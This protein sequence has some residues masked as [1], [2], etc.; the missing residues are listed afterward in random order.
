MKAAHKGG[1]GKTTVAVNLV[2]AFA[3]LRMRVLLVDIDPQRACA[4]GRCDG[5]APDCGRDV[6]RFP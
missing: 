2:G 1:S 3:N 4:G 6:L 5:G